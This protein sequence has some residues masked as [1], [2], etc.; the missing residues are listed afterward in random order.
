MAV[1]KGN[2][3]KVV[4]KKSVGKKVG[5][6][7]NKEQILNM[8]KKSANLKCSNMVAFKYG[9]TQICTHISL[10]KDKND[11]SCILVLNIQENGFTN[12]A[13]FFIFVSWIPSFGIIHEYN[14]R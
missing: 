5:K 11:H 6:N 2:T 3:K 12:R 7:H 1:K 4:V 8:F 10:K 13:Y 14:W 9:R